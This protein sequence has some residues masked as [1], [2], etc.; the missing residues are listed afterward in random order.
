MKLM[1]IEMEMES[2]KEPLFEA[3]QQRAIEVNMS[4]K[5]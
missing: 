5:V 2:N 1:A 4:Q 3:V